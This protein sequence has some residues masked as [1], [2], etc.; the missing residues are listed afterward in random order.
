MLQ[1]R[2]DDIGDCSGWHLSWGS[3][4]ASVPHPLVLQ[5]WNESLLCAPGNSVIPVYAV[6]LHVH[7]E[8]GSKHMDVI[9]VFQDLTANIILGRDYLLTDDVHFTIAEQSTWILCPRV[10]C[11]FRTSIA[12]LPSWKH[13]HPIM[14]DAVHF[15]QT[16]LCTSQNKLARMEEF[17]WHP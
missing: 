13:S 8:S 10:C 6:N 15:L 9:P 5:L 14:Y 3:G 1:V 4:V 12:S 11:V 17:D 7:T 2:G 16:V